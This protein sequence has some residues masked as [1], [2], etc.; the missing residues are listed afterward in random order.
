MPS[1]EFEEIVEDSRERLLPEFSSI[2]SS[3]LPEISEFFTVILDRQAL[4]PSPLLLLEVRLSMVLSELLKLSPF[5]PELLRLRFFKLL[6]EESSCIRFSAVDPSP[7]AVR[8]LILML[9]AWIQKSFDF[10][11][12]SNIDIAMERMC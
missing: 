1:S 11:G 3:K 9:E 2:P 5:F 10:L 4:I 8:L 12:D 7:I 6:T